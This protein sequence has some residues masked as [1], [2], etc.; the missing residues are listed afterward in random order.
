LLLKKP[1]TKKQKME[2]D[3]LAHEIINPLNIIVGCAEL[4]QIE[5]NQ[6]KNNKIRNYLDTIVSESMKCCSL[7]EQQIQERKNKNKYININLFNIVNHIS[8]SLKDHPLLEGRYI[9]FSNDVT[10]NKD[11]ISKTVS[12]L[13]ENK[14]YLKIIINNMLMNSIK[15]SSLDYDISINMKELSGHLILEIKNKIKSNDVSNHFTKSNYLG[16]NIID[17]LV[18]KLDYDWNLTQD[19][20]DIITCLII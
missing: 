3:M 12:I 16:L 4:S 19:G 17:S 1:T 11:L 8:A 5:I 9:Y 20:D 18:R 13:S 15:H 7:L 2:I 14:C 10:T 6:I